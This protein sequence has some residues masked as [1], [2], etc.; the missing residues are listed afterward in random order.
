MKILF[1]PSE[2]KSQQSP[3]KSDLKSS[4][5]F[6][7]HYDKRFEVLK[8]YNDILQSHNT[9]EL[10]KLIGLK[11]E[12]DILTYKD[13]DILSSSLQLAILRYTGVGYKYL[14]FNSLEEDAKQNILNSVIIFSNLLGPIRAGDKIPL[15]KLKQGENLQGFDL[16]RYYKENFSKSLDNFIGNDLLIDLRAGYYEKFYSPKIKRITMKFLKNGKAVSHFAKAYRGLALRALAVSNPQ[17]EEEFKNMLIP[18]LQ[19]KEIQIKGKNTIYIYDI[20]D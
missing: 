5:S 1:S 15:Y 14:D 2:A 8:K 16:S 4:L 17:N 13:I 10:S 9:K 3:I 6:H 12:A 18:D 11:K 20:L 7:E 19:I